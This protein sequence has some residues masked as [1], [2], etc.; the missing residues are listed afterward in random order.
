MVTS[1]FRNPRWQTKCW[2]QGF[3]M[4]DWKPMGDVM[5]AHGER[6]G[7]PLIGQL[8]VWSPGSSRPHVEVSFG[9]ILEHKLLLMAVWSVCECVWKQWLEKC[10][11]YVH[12]FLQSK[13]QTSSCEAYWGI[14]KYWT[15][16]LHLYRNGEA[17][18]SRTK[19]KNGR[20]VEGRGQKHLLVKFSH[21]NL[22]VF[23]R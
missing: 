15:L 7:R 1:D 13:V 12:Y 18:Y 6:A 11:I 21:L 20:S 17:A 5:V 4:G 8:E 16:F 19:V 22:A 2:T 14:M 3:E 10:T 23:G 9:K